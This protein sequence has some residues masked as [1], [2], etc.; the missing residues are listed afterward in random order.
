MTALSGIT[1]CSDEPEA[2]AE[3]FGRLTGRSCSEAESGYSFSLDE[4]EVRI[5]APAEIAEV[6]REAVLPAVPCVAVV[7]L[8]VYAL[9]ETKAYLE[10]NEITPHESEG[11]VWVR[12]ERAGGVILEFRD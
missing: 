6:Y 8:T 1:I 3:R 12:P 2:T 5:A 11:G 9:D 7:A 4:G 10:E